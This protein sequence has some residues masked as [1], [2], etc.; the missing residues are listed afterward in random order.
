MRQNTVKRACLEG[1]VQLGSWIATSDPLCAQIMATA[2]FDWVLM[3]MEHGP[4]PLKDLVNAI[5]AIRT[6]STQPFVRAAWNTSVAIQ[7]VLDCGVSGILVPMVSNRAQAEDVVRDARYLPLGE[8]SRG[9]LRAALSFDMD[10]AAYCAAANDEIL[11]MVQIETV[12]AM[13]NLEE[14]AALDGIDSLF[15]GP[16]DLSTSFGVEFP[17]CWNDKSSTYFQSIANLPK[18]AKKHGKIAG[19]Q[20][21]STDA[22][23]ECIALGYTLVA[24]GSDA[25]FLREQARRVAA[26]VKV[27]A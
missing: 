2:G 6:T 17:A 7:P 22:A 24:I 11:V 8:R 12:E 21:T 26:G 25:G 10:S 14:I 15:V 13:D 4:V 5:N 3:D 1:R 19:I 9:P 20:V 27:P 18:V 16:N 23:E